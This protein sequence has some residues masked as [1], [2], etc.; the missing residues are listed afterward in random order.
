MLVG[1]WWVLLLGLTDE[2][3]TALEE[4]LRTNTSDVTV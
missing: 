3:D 2:C 4:T 1:A